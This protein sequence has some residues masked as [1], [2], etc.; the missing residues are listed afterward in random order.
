MTQDMIIQYGPLTVPISGAV[1]VLVFSKIAAGIR[2]GVK[3]SFEWFRNQ[4][5]ARLERHEKTLQN[6]GEL[7]SA[8][9][10]N[11]RDLL[12]EIRAVKERFEDLKESLKDVR[13]SLDGYS[14]LMNRCMKL[15]HQVE[16]LNARHAANC[17]E[18]NVIQKNQE[19]ILNGLK[20][21]TK[22]D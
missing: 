19:T 9:N 20:K 22:K 8:A 3:A 2:S 10:L 15:D 1:L 7:I 5:E 14:E 16:S 12:I 18:M 4:I 21:L 13:H 6:H 17:A 11:T